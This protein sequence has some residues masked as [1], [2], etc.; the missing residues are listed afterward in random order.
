MLAPVGGEVPEP[1]TLEAAGEEFLDT[2]GGIELAVA[3]ITRYL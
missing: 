2:V 3:P 1:L